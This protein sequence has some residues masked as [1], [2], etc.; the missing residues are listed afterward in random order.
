MVTRH[1]DELR[2]RKMGQPFS[3]YQYELSVPGKITIAE[4]GIAVETLVINGDSE[5][6]RYRPQHL[7]D[8]RL[9]QQKWVVRNW[10][11]GERFWPAHT[12]EPKK[13]KE[14]L[15]DRHI[16]GDEKQ[17]WPVI[18]SGDE[19]IWV[20]GFGVRRD[21]QANGTEGVLIRELRET[22]K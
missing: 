17:L 8:S 20:R 7:V 21:F 11:A 4:A 9:A 6:Q 16:T 1:G 14:L 2:F 12:K 18:A 10:R 19:I 3:D 5:A 22:Q 15:Q 13:I